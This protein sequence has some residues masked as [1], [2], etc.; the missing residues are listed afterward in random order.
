M[1][2]NLRSFLG[3]D[4]LRGRFARSRRGED[5][6]S[7]SALTDHDWRLTADAKMVE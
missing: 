7:S 2:L 3:D 6:I 4:A 5:G 1:I